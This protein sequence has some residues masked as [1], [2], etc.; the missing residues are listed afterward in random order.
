MYEHWLYK[1]T[2]RYHSYKH[3]KYD[4]IHKIKEKIIQQHQ[5]RKQ[6]IKDGRVNYVARARVEMRQGRNEG[7]NTCI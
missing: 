6:E 4:K 5:V 7:R 2:W 3:L 1:L